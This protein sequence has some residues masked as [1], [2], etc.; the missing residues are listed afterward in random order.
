MRNKLINL[1]MFLLIAVIICCSILLLK[2]E[3]EYKKAN[4]EYQEITKQVKKSKKK[5]KSG[6]GIDFQAL[7]T[8]NP[9][10]VGWIQVKDTQIDYPIIQ[11]KNNE[12][13]L[14][15][16][17]LGN[18]NPSGAI[19]LD[20][21]AKKDFGSANS[22]IYGHH[23]K[24]GSMFADLLKF[25]K[26]TFA[27]THRITLWMPAKKISLKVFAAYA[28]KADTT[29]PVE[30]ESDTE[31]SLFLKE[32]MERSEIQGNMSRKELRKAGQIYTFVTCS[33]EHDDYRTIVH[34]IERG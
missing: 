11:G 31:K 33:Y 29:L 17:F 15:E 34:A 19:F 14:H 13:Y 9:D 2:T 23:M 32:I 25:R 1:A 30:F 28:R 16:T 8:K 27:D 7:L 3:K 20:A 6:Q 10:T 12:K 4:Q 21:K 24:N 5:N 18:R 26:Q 22:I